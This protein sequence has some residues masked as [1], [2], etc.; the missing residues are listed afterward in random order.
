SQ[1][2]DR[3]TQLDRPGGGGA[4]RQPDHPIR[5]RDVV[6]ARPHAAGRRMRI[7]RLIPVGHHDVLDRPD[8]LEAGRL[9]GL[10]QLDGRSA[11][12]VAAQTCVPQSEL[13]QLPPTILAAAPVSLTMCSPVLAR[14]A[15]Y[16]NPRS[17][18]STLLVWIATLQ[19]RVPF[20]TQ[21][22]AV[23]SVV[24]GM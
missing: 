18:A 15:R 8:R 22:S 2:L 19:L 21:R 13:H 5:D 16:T 7:A 4:V 1:D 24:A 23:R 6:G 12:G 9:G 11:V 3:R 10:G 14:S 17:S 20:V